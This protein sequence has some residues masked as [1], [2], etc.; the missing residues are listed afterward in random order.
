MLLLVKS[1]SR[2]FL[3]VKIITMTLEEVTFL[4]SGGEIR[5]QITMPTSATILQLKQMINE[6]IRVPVSRQNL[7]YGNTKLLDWTPINR[8]NFGTFTELILATDMYPDERVI[9]VSV[10]SPAFD[11]GL[12][13]NKVHKVI[14]VKQ[15][16]AEICAIDTESITLWYMSKKM[17][18][19]KPLY[20]Y[21][22]TDGSQI[23]F[24]RTGFST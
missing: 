4:I 14:Q 2:R 16:L 15:K 24:T 23:L 8:Y 21:Y 5:P 12:R 3:R 10:S 18:D 1:F 13:V 11:I 9:T 7:L 22:I 19:E 20:K 17:Q 6:K